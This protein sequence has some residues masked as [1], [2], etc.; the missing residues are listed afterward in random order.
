[1]T[2][3]KAAEAVERY[4][5]LAV[6]PQMPTKEQREHARASEL[7]KLGDIRLVWVNES[8]LDLLTLAQSVDQGMMEEWQTVNTAP[9]ACHVLAARFDESCGDWVYGVVLSPP[10]HPFTHWR[11]LPAPPRTLLARMNGE[12]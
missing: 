7:Y 8:D 12:G 1:M 11:P 10:S 4:G 6:L 9:E 3:S 5:P 2:D